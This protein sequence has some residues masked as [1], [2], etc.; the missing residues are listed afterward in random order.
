MDPNNGG[1]QGENDNSIQKLEE[2]LNSLKQE[3]PEVSA[4]EVAPPSLP[5]IDLP[6]EPEHQEDEVVEKADQSTNLS[7]TTLVHEIPQAV[8]PLTKIAKVLLV[9][10]LL[11]LA[12]YFVGTFVSNKKVVTPTPTLVPT[13]VATIDPTVDW[14]TYTNNKFGISL[15]YPDRFNLSEEVATV[16]F[17]FRVHFEDRQK[18][19]VGFNVEVWPVGV[20]EAIQKVKNVSA[21]AA[22][23]IT[24]IPQS[25]IM[26]DNVSGTNLVLES[27]RLESQSTIYVVKYGQHSYVLTFQTLPNDN[28]WIDQI[29]STFRFLGQDKGQKMYTNSKLGLSFSYPSDLIYVYDYLNN[30][31]DKSQLTGSLSLQNFADKGNSQITND[32]F[33]IAIW[34]GKD[35]GITLDKLAM[36]AGSKSIKHT[37]VNGVDSV[38]G[39]S[40]QKYQDVPT[41]WLIN[42]GVLYTLQLSTPSSI[43]ATWFDQILST[44]KFTK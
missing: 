20:D 15:K 6:S 38:K 41:V 11:A 12:A 25:Q 19:A 13:P 26:I 2:N 39:T 32:D 29:L 1:E 8:S 9:V 30:F 28:K 22:P 23:P 36:N 17:L 4:P 7:E 27:D 21:K 35:T 18:Q 5:A 33:Q 34:V 37:T 40:V 43:N 10:S 24:N 3:V 44:F 42:K 14:K 16:D 31:T